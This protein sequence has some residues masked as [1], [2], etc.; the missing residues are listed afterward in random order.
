MIFRGAAERRKVGLVI[1]F[2]RVFQA[3]S[4]SSSTFVLLP[5]IVFY[6]RIALAD[7][8]NRMLNSHV[9]LVPDLHGN[10]SGASL[11]GSWLLP[12]PGAQRKHPWNRGGVSQAS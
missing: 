8:S 4:H 6:S 5:V 7:P 2:L 9:D 3:Y 1:V 11:L 10:A 12:N